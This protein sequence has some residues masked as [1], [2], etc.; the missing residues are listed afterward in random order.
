VQPSNPALNSSRASD[1][2]LLASLHGKSRSTRTSAL[3]ALLYG[4]DQG[5]GCRHG[6]LYLLYGRHSVSPCATFLL[7]LSLTHP[8]SLS[9]RRRSS[10]L[11]G[12]LDLFRVPYA[13]PPLPPLVGE[14]VG[15]WR[16]CG[17]GL[18]LGLR[19]Y[20]GLGAIHIPVLSRSAVRLIV[21][22]S[23]TTGTRR[24]REG[25]KV[26]PAASRD[27]CYGVAPSDPGRRPW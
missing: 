13:R 20:R 22:T 5:C 27:R 18:L 21:I 1:F 7:L 2:D 4:G 25:L 14:A 26:L 8:A 24:R 15:G 10:A 12:S 11:P 17:A 3:P 16:P 19:L 23:R 9:I 6:M